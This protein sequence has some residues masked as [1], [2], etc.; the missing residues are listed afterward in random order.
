MEQGGIRKTIEIKRQLA[1]PLKQIMED[2]GLGLDELVNIGLYELMVRTGHIRP[3]SVPVA[4]PT[5]LEMERMPQA[6]PSSSKPPLSRPPP[7]APAPVPAATEEA[8]FFQ[9][10]GGETIPVRK[11]VFLLGRGSKC[12]YIL[13]DP[14]VSREHA[15]ITK[16]RSGWFIEDLN[17]ANGVWLNGEQISKHKLSHGDV[18]Q[19][20]KYN[21]R[22]VIQAG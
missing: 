9:V 21:I 17:S 4:P 12:D 15:V 20:C 16:E 13:R 3:Q 2:S 18:I 1:K 5:R 7:R 6:A 22:F 11:R 8:L 14:G 10:D 19:I